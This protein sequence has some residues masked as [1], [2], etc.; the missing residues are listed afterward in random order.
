MYHEQPSLLPWHPL[1]FPR[2]D[3]CCQFPLHLPEIHYADTIL[4]K[5]P[6]NPDVSPSPKSLPSCSIEWMGPH[7][8]SAVSCPSTFP[9]IVFVMKSHFL[10]WKPRRGQILQFAKFNLAP[11]FGACTLLPSNCLQLLNCCP[12]GSANGTKV[13]PWRCLTLVE[14]RGKAPKRHYLQKEFYFPFQS[15]ENV[16]WDPSFQQILGFKCVFGLLFTIYIWKTLVFPKL[17]QRVRL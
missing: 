8:G 4:C 17:G 12:G 9:G 2:G 5:E 6:F 3:H 1:H 14:L 13:S 16:F 15:G 11:V 7:A 10:N